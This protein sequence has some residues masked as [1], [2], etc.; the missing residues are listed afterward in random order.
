MLPQDRHDAKDNIKTVSRMVQS[1][2][3]TTIRSVVSIVSVAPYTR[4]KDAVQTAFVL[5]RHDDND[6]DTVGSCQIESTACW[7]RRNDQ[8]FDL[9][10]TAVAAEIIWADSTNG[11]RTIPMHLCERLMNKKNEALLNLARTIYAQDATFVNDDVGMPLMEMDGS[12]CVS[13]G[14]LVVCPG[15]HSATYVLDIEQPHAADGDG[16]LDLTN[17][18]NITITHVVQN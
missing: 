12:M 18:R 5:N 8:L 17:V 14:V 15:G 9:F 13:R 2:E 4:Y 3:R 11:T 10:A 16:T 6:D 7:L 1:F